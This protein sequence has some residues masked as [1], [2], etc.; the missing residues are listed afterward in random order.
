MQNI[1]SSCF[2]LH[3]FEGFFASSKIPDSLFMQGENFKQRL[4][5]F[6]NVGNTQIYIKMVLLLSIWSSELSLVFLFKNESYYLIWNGTAAPVLLKAPR[7]LKGTWKPLCVSVQTSH[8]PLP[9]LT[10][11]GRVNLSHGPVSCGITESLASWIHRYVPFIYML[12]W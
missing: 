6:S 8:R 10:G 11:T 2:V 1:N 7:H 5:C 9:L 12:K 4:N 3:P